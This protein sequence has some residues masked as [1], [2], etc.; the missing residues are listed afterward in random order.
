M[1][2]RIVLPVL[3]SM[4]ILSI[5]LVPAVYA[6]RPGFVDQVTCGTNEGW[7]VP[8]TVNINTANAP[9]NVGGSGNNAVTLVKDAIS[10]YWNEGADVDGEDENGASSAFSNTGFGTVTE[11]GAGAIEI[12]FVSLSGSTI[13]Q[14]S[15]TIDPSTGKII[16]AVV[17]LTD[18]ASSLSDENYKN[19]AAHEL[20]H[21]IG[22]RS[23][24]GPPGTLMFRVLS[25]GDA[26]LPLSN[27]S[28]KTLSRLY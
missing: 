14:A 20:G 18:D 28:Q 12:S 2:K 1:S 23:H 6:P 27:G 5:G 24:G 4:L 9:T 17:Q 3:A 7:A 21:A 26:Y 8:P 25:D 13:G 19:I 15:C 16:S 22:L 11:N 10:D